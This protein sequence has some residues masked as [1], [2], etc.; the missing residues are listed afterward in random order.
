MDRDARDLGNPHSGPVSERIGDRFPR[1][2]PPGHL[3]RI[4]RTGGV[5]KLQGAALG[6]YPRHFIEGPIVVPDLE[7]ENRKKVSTGFDAEIGRM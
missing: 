1:F 7:S 5:A 2:A 4:T 3:S 6:V